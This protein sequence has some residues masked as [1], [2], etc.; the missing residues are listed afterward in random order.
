M[1]SII[2]VPSCFLL[3]G[4]IV[5]CSHCSLISY[6]LSFYPLLHHA[7]YLYFFNFHTGLCLL[8]DIQF[9]FLT[10]FSFKNSSVFFLTPPSPWHSSQR[11]PVIYPPCWAMYCLEDL[12]FS[13]ELEVFA[14]PFKALGNCQARRDRPR[15]KRTACQCSLLPICSLPKGSS[16]LI[17]FWFLAMNTT[18]SRW[19]RLLFAL[20]GL[21]IRFS[22]NKNWELL[23]HESLGQWGLMFY[24]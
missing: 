24:V 9:Y 2:K 6:S 4:Q 22:A 17:E 11:F 13:C 19:L 23:E 12:G 8:N 14:V 1:I 5:T 7:F 15:H 16:R 20:P 18:E 10:L 21:M 3:D